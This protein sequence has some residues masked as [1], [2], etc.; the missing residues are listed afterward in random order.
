MD[1]ECT[2]C[3]TNYHIEMH[4]ERPVLTGWSALA[5]TA[6]AI[7]HGFA[8]I[9]QATFEDLN[10]QLIQRNEVKTPSEEEE[11]EYQELPVGR[12]LSR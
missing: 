7:F 3:G 10:R 5:G 11:P 12:G 4:E 9:A 8:Q 1:F 6:L 2:E